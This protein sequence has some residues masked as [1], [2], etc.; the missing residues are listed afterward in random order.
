MPQVSVRDLQLA[1]LGVLKDFDRLCAD[2]GMQYSLAAGTLL[3]A[4][5]H[6]GFIPWDDDV[7]LFMPREDFDLLLSISDDELAQRGY[8]LQRPFSEAWPSGYAKLCKNGTTY[9]ENYKYK[10][11]NQHHGIFIDIMPIDN[12]SNNRFVQKLQWISYR[13]ITAKALANRGYATRSPLKLLAM[14][15]AKGIPDQFLR[16][17]VINREDRSSDKVHS[18]LGSAHFFERN[19]FPRTTIEAYTK[20]SFEG[21]PF[22]V[23]QN[24]REVLTVQYGDYMTPPPEAE[25]IAA[26]HAVLVDLDREWSENEIK[27]FIQ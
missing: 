14:M 16:K 26:L 27:S 12:L 7:D 21:V 6:E 4:V 9:L 19:I 11:R 18:F 10:N 20:L 23:M 24:Y 3:G 8:T 5:R 25:R 13:I 2:H 17:I 15:I 22:S 1:L